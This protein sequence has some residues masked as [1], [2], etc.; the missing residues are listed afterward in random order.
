MATALQTD[1]QSGAAR[2]RTSLRDRFYLWQTLVCA[3]IAIGGFLPTYWLQLAPRTFIGPPLLHIHGALCTLWIMFLVLQASLVNRGKIRN[4]RD[5]GLAGIAL[6]TAV[7]IVGIS[8][9]IV[10]LKFELGRGL[11]DAARSFLAV[12]LAAMVRFAIFTGSAIA[13]TH[14]PDWHK[15]FMITGTVGLIEAAAARIAF[16]LAVGYGPGMRPGLLPPPPPAIPIAVGLLLQL[17]IIAGMIHDRRTRGSVH[18]AWTIGLIGSVAVIL[19]KVP[20]STTVGWLAFA[21]WT[22]RIAG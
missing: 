9:A 15:R 10:S 20:L 7:I 4:H 6:A 19:L 8:A 5:W 17:I 2:V 16:A 18:P 3:A 11:G 21:D 14:R 22:S 13:F 12:P 1:R